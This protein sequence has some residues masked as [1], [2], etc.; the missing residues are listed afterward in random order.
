FLRA[1]GAYP[2]NRDTADSR[3][4]RWAKGQL[5]KDHVLA[6]FP[7]GTRSKTGGMQEAKHGVTRLAME[8]QTAILPIG[9]TGTQ[10][11]GTLLRHFNPTGTIRVNIGMPFTLPHIE[12]K[13]SKELVESM[14]DMVMVRIAQLLPEEFRGVYTKKAAEQH[15]RP[16]VQPT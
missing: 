9:I 6:M 3:A 15:G 11:L 16:S 2:L 4:Y 5:A 12:G 8:T 1:Y 13:P 10:G 7:E 14:T